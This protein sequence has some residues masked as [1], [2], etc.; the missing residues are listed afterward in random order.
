[1]SVTEGPACLYRCSPVF[2]V[3]KRGSYKGYTDT[4]YKSAIASTRRTELAWYVL[5]VLRIPMALS[6][7]G[8]IQV[9][10]RRVKTVAE[11]GSHMFRG[12][13]PSNGRLN[14]FSGDSR[15]SIEN[16]SRVDT[17]SSRGTTWIDKRRLL[18]KVSFILQQLQKVKSWEELCKSVVQKRDDM[19]RQE[20]IVEKDKRRLLRKVSF[21]LQQ[22]QKV[23]SW[24]EVC[25]SVVQ[26]RDDMDRQEKI[27]E[28]VQKRD[29]MDR[30]EKIV[31]KVQKRDDMDRQEKI[32]E[33]DKRRL[34]RKVSFILQQLQKV[35]SWEEVCKS[36][37]Q[38]RDDM[39]RQ[40]KIVEKEEFEMIFVTQRQPRN[41]SVN[42]TPQQ[43]QQTCSHWPTNSLPHHLCHWTPPLAVT[44]QNFWMLEE[45]TPLPYKWAYPLSPS[46]FSSR[47]YLPD[48]EQK[49]MQALR[50]SSRYRDDRSDFS[51]A[52]AR[53]DHKVARV[54][55]PPRVGWTPPPPPNPRVVQGQEA[56]END[57][58]DT[59][60]HARCLIAPTRKTCRVSIVTLY[61]AN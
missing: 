2:L 3:E 20:K 53:S 7:V 25:K 55:G 38:K 40:E 31:E 18:R 19:D 14:Y 22:L 4:R 35:K 51:V 16:A 47:S 24:E 11:N 41:N 27:V 33:K 60:M 46:V 54:Q 5:V 45:S 39:D 56:R 32:V 30:Q 58:G 8:S 21:I 12:R 44:V 36:V 42:Y 23:K 6:A 26:K 37:V 48:D 9:A 28:K 1:M 52:A 59:N 61:C 49:R 10:S 17:P 29:D 43:L 57:T 50:D 34:L 13:V 15:I